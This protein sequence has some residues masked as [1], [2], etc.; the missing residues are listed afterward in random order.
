MSRDLE[1]LPT[2]RLRVMLKD[3]CQQRGVAGE[4]WNGPRDELLRCLRALSRPPRPRPARDVI[5]AA[6]A[7]IDYYEDPANGYAIPVDRYQQLPPPERKRFRSVGLPYAT[8]L[9]IVRAE[10]PSARTTAQ[11]LRRTVAFV[12]SGTPGYEVE[13]PA[14]RPR[15]NSARPRFYIDSAFSKTL[16]SD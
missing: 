13:L 2:P 10:L 1:T 9:E 7:Q 8:V 5:L 14:R 16:P 11:S 4:P 3:A 6:L 15:P 12:R